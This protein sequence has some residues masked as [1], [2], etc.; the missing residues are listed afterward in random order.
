MAKIMRGKGNY[1]VDSDHT[2]ELH[3]QNGDLVS[4]A[5]AK[6]KKTK[7]INMSPFSKAFSGLEI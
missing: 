7:K 1:G 5:D 4:H 3:V 6:T 2:S